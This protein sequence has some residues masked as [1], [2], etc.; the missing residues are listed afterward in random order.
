[1]FSV[2]LELLLYRQFR[3][4]YIILYILITIKLL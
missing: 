4:I 2:Y 1:M 3:Y